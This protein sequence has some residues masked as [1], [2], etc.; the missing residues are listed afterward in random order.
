MF[1]LLLLGVVLTAVCVALLGRA[2]ALP[3]LRAI[4]RLGQI[5]AYGFSASVDGAPAAAGAVTGA[6][7]P[8]REGPGLVLLRPHE[9][10]LGGGQQARADGGRDVPHGTGD[11]RGLSRDLPQ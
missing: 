7:E 9:G 4:G 5:D 3:R 10:S 8:A 1:L 11:A 2:V 6:V